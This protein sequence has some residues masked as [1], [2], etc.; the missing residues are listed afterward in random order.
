MVVGALV[1]IAGLWMA[2]MGDPNASYFV[3]LGVIAM[4]VG[5]ASPLM[6]VKLGPWLALVFIILGFVAASAGAVLLSL[7]GG[8]LGSYL[9]LGGVEAI[10]GGLFLIRLGL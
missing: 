10:L 7:T 1:I 4:I 2:A 8:S 9:A 5:A 3:E 6:G